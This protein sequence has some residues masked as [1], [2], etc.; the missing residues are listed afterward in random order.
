MRTTSIDTVFRVR[1]KHLPGQFARLANAL[2]DEGAL[3]G[4]IVTIRS[5]DDDTVR[6]VTVETESEEHAR[7]VVARVHALDGIEVLGVTDRVFALHQ[8][9]K[10]H[11]TSRVALN[12]LSDLRFVY[13][14]GVARVAKELQRDPSRAFELTTLGN[15]VG[16]FTNGTRVLGL[17]AVGPLASLPVMEGKAVLYDVCAKISATPILIDT[18]DVDAFIETVVRVAPSFGGIHLED[19]R[20]PDCY[21]IEDELLRRLDK[22][23]MHDDQHGTATVA[24]AAVMNACAITGVA[25]SRA[26]VGQIG[27]GAAGSAI[28]R[29]ALSLGVGE[30]IVHDRSPEA[31]GWLAGL[32]ARPAD[33][34]TVMR[35]A[36][37][38]ISTTGVPGLIAPAMVRR[39]QVIFALSNPTPEIEPAVALEAGAAFASDGRSINNALAFPGLFRAA[40]DVRSRAISPQM[41]IAAARAIA[42]CAEKGEVV[43]SPLDAKV[44]AAVRDAAAA[45]AREQGLA[46]TARCG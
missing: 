21:R 32:G 37:I 45:T 35:E 40:L 13:T 23:V 38:V 34:A 16:I 5:G 8:G 19:I 29:L 11:S 3:V 2:A 22:P 6:E 41:R 28:A 10:L 24:L 33:L 46:G 15:S 31:M 36:D 25:L 9:G 4:D 39:G 26:R 42:A 18:T 44:H 12:K 17:G 7:R 43:P 14:P 20:I 30:V 1:L 27:L